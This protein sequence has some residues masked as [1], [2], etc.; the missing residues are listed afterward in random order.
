[1]LIRIRD[2]ESFRFG[3]RDGKIRIR[4]PG[5]ISQIRNTVVQNR[6]FFACSRFSKLCLGTSF[7]ICRPTMYR[8]KSIS[9]PSPQSAAASASGFPHR[10]PLEEK[11]NQEPREEAGTGSAG[12]SR[13]LETSSSL[14]H[15]SLASSSGSGSS[16]NSSQE[17]SV[18]AYCTQNKCSGS[19]SFLRPGSGP[20]P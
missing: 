14:M 4:D 18:P 2:P 11:E 5:W 6:E 20:I 10:P 12:H 13:D 7:F 19:V 15:Q 16:L 8:K 1:M 9:R 3:I 17:D